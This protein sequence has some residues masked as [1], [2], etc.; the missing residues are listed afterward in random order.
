V[1]G[2][3]KR[4]I[5]APGIIMEHMHSMVGKEKND[6]LTDLIWNKLQTDSIKFEKYIKNNLDND[7]K[8]IMEH[9]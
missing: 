6:E 2:N 1:F 7:L 5:Y 9:E 4:A 8:K 3:L